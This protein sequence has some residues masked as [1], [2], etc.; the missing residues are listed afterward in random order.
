MTNP[1]IER[2]I[3]KIITSKKRNRIEVSEICFYKAR[4]DQKKHEIDEEDRLSLQEMESIGR[5]QKGF[6]IR[7]EVLFFGFKS[8][9]QILREK[10][11]LNHESKSR[12]VGF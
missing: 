4:A 7:T 2:E 10:I 12:M 3:R 5:K 6:V 9:I 1:S 11:D 8:P